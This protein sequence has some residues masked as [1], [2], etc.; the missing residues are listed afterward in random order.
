MLQHLVGIAGMILSILENHNF[1]LMKFI[2]LIMS[3]F[4]FFLVIEPGLN[5]MIHLTDK[6]ET[7]KCCCKH[8]CNKNI[9]KQNHKQKKGCCNNDDCNPFT[10]C[11]CCAGFVVTS[12]SYSVSPIASYEEYCVATGEDMDSHFFHN[13]WQPPKLS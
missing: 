5:A 12:V 8:C 2:A 7:H 13:F 1:V 9:N 6:Q 11:Q 4:V 10:T 3:L